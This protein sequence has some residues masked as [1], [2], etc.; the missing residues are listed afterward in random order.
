MIS[1]LYI[2]NIAVIK[3]ALIEFGSGFSVITGETGAGKSILIDSLNAILGARV[4]RDMVRS[5]SKNA[6]IIAKFV[7]L[8]KNIKTK[9][10][11]LGIDLEEDSLIIQ[12]NIGID[13]K[14]SCRINQKPVSASSVKL[15]APYLININGQ[16]ESSLL[17]NEERHIQYLDSTGDYKEE[18]NEYK[19]IYSKLIKIKNNLEKLDLDNSQKLRE[20]DLLK[21]QINEIEEANFKPG[22]VEALE[23]RRNILLNSEK[24]SNALNFAYNNLNGEGEFYGV[25]QNLQETLKQLSLAS[26]F[27]KNLTDITN[28]VDSALCELED[29]SGEINNYKDEMEFSLEE[30]DKIENRLDLFSKLALKYGKTQAEQTEFLNNCKERLTSIELSQDQINKFKIEFKEIKHQAETL[31]QII[32]NK[33][34]ENAKIFVDKIKQ[35]LNFLDMPKVEFIIN[36]TKSGLNSFGCDL[37]SFEISVNPGEKPKP[38][39]KV[40][41]GG[42]LARIMLAIK[43]TLAENIEDSTMIFDEIDTGISGS[44]SEK[45]GL[46]LKEIS[47]N[48]QV[49]CVTHCAQIASLADEHFLIHKNIEEGKTFTKINKLDFE[50]RKDE[51]ARIIGGV[52]ITEINLKNAEEMLRG[53]INKNEI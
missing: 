33:R 47:K 25:L 3:K 24:I 44:T 18:L 23:E 50:G 37:I 10:N 15:I 1:E 2:E 34:K 21:F 26:E 14:S 51:I 32:S 27:D 5:D 39:A 20:C 40:A 28:R 22:E 19:S 46:K 53:H 43:S 13:G 42:E 49:M 35:E 29:C 38:L 41:S 9:L 48:R 4:N 12:R 11:K 52:N 45:V 31:A 16:N 36:Q 6:T 30:L 7:N 17:L 8:N